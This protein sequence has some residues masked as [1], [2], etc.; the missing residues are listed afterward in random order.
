MSG[1]RRSSPSSK[2]DEVIV[3]I[4]DFLLNPDFVGLPF[5]CRA[6]ACLLKAGSRNECVIIHLQ[7]TPLEYVI[8]ESP[9]V[10]EI[11]ITS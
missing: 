7:D 2:H 3:C 6:I 11:N 1:T 9:A 5:N 10:P 4:S 8:M